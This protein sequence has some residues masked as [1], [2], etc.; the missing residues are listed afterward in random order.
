MITFLSQI[1]QKA[2][3]NRIYNR[4]YKLAIDSHAQKQEKKNSVI[5]AKINYKRR[6]KS[7]IEMASARGDKAI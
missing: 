3:K 6:K 2:E 5:K 4:I 1:C 7:V